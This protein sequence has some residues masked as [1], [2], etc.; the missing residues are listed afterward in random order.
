MKYLK[1]MLEYN[2]EN[3]IRMNR[4]I[5]R[6]IEKQIRIHKKYIYRPEKVEQAIDFIEKNFM[7]TTGDLRPIKLLP[8]QLWWYELMLGYYMIDEEGDEV[9]LVN[10]VFLNVGRG[11]G[12]STLMATRV[13]NWMILGGQYGG[14]SQVIAYDNNQAKHVFD[15]VRDQSRASLL[16]SEMDDFNMFNSTKQ[17]LKFESMNTKFGKQTNDVN[18]AQGG[19]TSLNV[20]DEVHVY[21]DDITEAVNKGSRMK[22]KNWQ[23]IYITSGGTTRKGLYDKL[24][25]RFTSDAEFEND[26]SVALLYRLEDTQ[27]VK[28]KRNWGMALPLIGSLPRWSSVEEEYELSKGDP[29][30]QVKFLAMSMGIAM[31]DVHGFFTAGEAMKKPFNLDV[32]RGA[33]TY[34]GID[35]ALHGDLSSIAFLTRDDEDCYLHTINFTTLK[36]FESLDYDIQELYRRFEEEGS[37]VILD[38]GNNYMS[39]KDMI[40]YMIKF[41]KD[42]GC[43]LRMVGYDRAR[44]ENLEKLIEKFFFDKDGDKQ[45][46]VKQGFAMSDYIKIFK[47]QFKQDNVHHNQE[48]LEWSLMNVAVKVG[49]S[50]DLVLKKTTNSKKI[51]PVVASVMALQ[52]MLRDEY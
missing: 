22:Q 26:R 5:K 47:S 50:D 16:L 13:L 17:G 32:F 40:P 19:D 1:Q 24:I 38:T 30:L 8:P 27:Q 37:L 51:D 11:T 49:T 46:P 20:F 39:A 14:T 7:L 33:R 9:L 2:K 52:T 31:N 48:L 4:D 45:K 3:N 42:T 6:Q 15:Q 41:K 28:D 36:E 43:I 35:L 10:E 23:S 18:R 34:C 21:K 12:K 29:A 44:Y 25:K